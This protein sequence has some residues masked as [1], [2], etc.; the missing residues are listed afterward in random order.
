MLKDINILRKDKSFIT[1]CF[2]FEIMKSLNQDNIIK[3]KSGII[4]FKYEFDAKWLYYFLVFPYSFKIA[5]ESKIVTNIIYRNERKNDF[6]KMLEENCLIAKRKFLKMT[7]NSSGDFKCDGILYASINEIKCIMELLGQSFHKTFDRLIDEVNLRR[8]IMKHQVLV[9]KI[10]DKIVGVLIF[11]ILGSLSRLEF[12]C[13][14]KRY[15]K[16][17]FGRELMKRYFSEI[18]HKKSELWVSSSNE[19]AIYFYEKLG[20]SR[21]NW[22][23]MY[24]EVFANYE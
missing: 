8:L 19:M 15:Q 1:N 7:K 17:G 3:T 21:D 12:L 6:C 23:N 14:D 22:D 13:V 4:F 16:M 18:G 20:Y 10:E 11:A 24:N 9:L 5:N 2:N